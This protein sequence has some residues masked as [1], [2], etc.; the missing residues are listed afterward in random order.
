MITF[1][2]KDG[3]EHVLTL[4]EF[5]KHL[6]TKMVV[7]EIT[8]SCGETF[9]KRQFEPKNYHLTMKT[10]LRALYATI[11]G[12]PEEQKVLAHNAFAE[13]VR[14]RMVSNDKFQREVI[15]YLAQMDGISAATADIQDRRC[16]EVYQEGFKAA[17][18]AVPQTANPYAALQTQEGVQ[19]TTSW[20]DGWASAVKAD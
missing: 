5:T 9:Q 20:N 11:E 14:Q 12:V 19:L 8:V 10:D 4:D 7:D 3:V 13:A 17:N 2:D 1:V 6:R 16:S 15:R 18:E